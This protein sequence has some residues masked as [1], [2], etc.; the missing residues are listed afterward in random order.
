MMLSERIGF[1]DLTP[2][3]VRVIIITFL[4]RLVYYGVCCGKST[5]AVSVQW[6]WLLHV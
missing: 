1:V 4:F 5:D 3:E 2:V 6:A